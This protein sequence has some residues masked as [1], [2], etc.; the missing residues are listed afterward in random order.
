MLI[1]GI[2]ISFL[3]FSQGTID[4]VLPI[5][6]LYLAAFLSLVIILLFRSKNA[7]AE[8]NAPLL[9]AAAAGILLQGLSS[10]WAINSSEALLQTLKSGLF[11][12]LALLTAQLIRSG[13]D[14]R[15]LAYSMA[16]LT[17]LLSFIGICQYYQLGFLNIP[18]HFI[19]YATMVNKNLFASV[20]VLM[21]PFL[22]YAAIVHRG[23]GS[24][25]AMAGVIASSVAIGHAHSRAA[26][27]ALITLLILSGVCV[28]RVLAKSDLDKQAQEI[29]RKRLVLVLVICGL[30]TGLSA[31]LNFFSVAVP[32]HI[33][34]AASS[35]VTT[36]RSL[37]ERQ[38]LW[39]KTLGMIVDHPVAGV[40]AE[41]WKIKFPLYSEGNM[42]SA[43]GSVQFMRPH[44]DFLWIAGENGIPGLLLYL[45]LLGLA[46]LSIWKAMQKSS[47][48]QERLFACFLLAFFAVFI[49]ISNFSFP[50]ERVAHST[51]FWM[52][53]GIVLQYPALRNK[54]VRL[55]P[56]KILLS[57]MLLTTLSASVVYYSRLQSE[58]ALK[59]SFTANKTQNWSTAL[60]FAKASQSSLYT[61]DP[62]ATSPAFFEGQAYIKLNKMPEAAEAL[63]RAYFHN[64]NHI[65]ALGNLAAARHRLDDLDA[66]EKLF[67]EALLISPKLESLLIN[68]S[69]VYFKQGR[70]K[71][72]LAELDKCDPNSTNPRIEQYRAIYRQQAAGSSN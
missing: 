40:G 32:K 60:R 7:A 53:I 41:N 51:L 49:V 5:R 63:Q 17:I 55:Q 45:G 39:Q 30:A 14:R 28:I 68:L 64:P 31:L 20:M 44:N 38:Q 15:F 9:Y 6:L 36:T 47:T 3:L 19:I 21:L 65:L 70:V 10:F 43:D 66:A 2:F 35:S 4:P 57:L 62:S 34:E 22:L 16:V 59:Q 27:L 61:I 72:A 23:S 54:T 71:E 26:W 46:I 29:I 8:I 67:K 1:A 11:L 56:Q 13:E 48:P 50:R 33:T 37:D 42:R 24:L 12:I 25:L 58:I 52:S 69:A 18:G